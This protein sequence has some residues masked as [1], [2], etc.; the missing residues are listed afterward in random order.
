MLTI[1]SSSKKLSQELLCPDSCHGPTGPSPC[2]HCGWKMR[3]K[4][5]PGT[6]SSHCHYPYHCCSSLVTPPR[7]CQREQMLFAFLV[8][9]VDV[10][11]QRLDQ[12]RPCAQVTGRATAT[13]CAISSS[14]AAIPI[15]VG[16]FGLFVLSFSSFPLLV[17]KKLISKNKNLK[18]MA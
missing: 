18:G 15:S 11:G 2:L 13:A 16:S 14:R 4:L 7:N 10:L 12:I 17:P 6:H 1:V 8:L 3:K 9:V 5:A